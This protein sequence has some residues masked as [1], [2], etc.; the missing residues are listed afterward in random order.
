MFP[1]LGGIRY[2]P[3]TARVGLLRAP[4]DKVVR[5]SQPW[6]GGRG[7]FYTTTRHDCLDG[8]LTAHAPLPYLVET[9]ELAIGAGNGEWTA[10]VNT[11]FPIGDVIGYLQARARLDLRCEFVGVEWA[12]HTGDVSANAQFTHYRPAKRLFGSEP[13][14]GDL[15]WVQ[16]SEQDDGWDFSE[17]GP[18]RDFEE[19]DRYTA[20]RK[21]DRLPYE[22]LR[23]YLAAVGVPVDD[24][25]WLSGP[26]AVA[27]KPPVREATSSW[28]SAAELRRL[29]GYPEDR[30]PTELVRWS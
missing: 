21:A 2:W 7:S 20:R 16:A 19:P 5:S 22:V 9:A 23:R 24:G 28:S 1:C 26:V 27:V 10:V 25:G 15:R 8:A 11:G 13:P 29:C 17:S 18:P 3:L 4:L 30:I 12:P 14:P 6:K